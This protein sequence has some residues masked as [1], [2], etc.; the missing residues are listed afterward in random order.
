[1]NKKEI[2][3]FVKKLLNIIW[4]NQEFD[5]LSEFYHKD[6][7]GYYNTDRVTFENLEKKVRVIHKHLKQ[8]KIEVLHLVIEKDKYALYANQRF[9]TLENKEVI[10]PSMLFAHLKK[11]KISEYW[12]KTKMPLDFG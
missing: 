8:L 2:Q 11:G 9:V 10:I 1:M 4:E 3:S 7:I 12:L 5:K 6:V